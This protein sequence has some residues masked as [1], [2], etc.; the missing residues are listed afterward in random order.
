M[1]N[2]Q[3]FIFDTNVIV[4]AFLFNKSKPRQ[5]FD[6]A[7]DIGIIIL[8]NPIFSELEEVLSRPK[9]NKYLS[10][11]RRKEFLDNFM[12]TVQFIDVNEQID[13]CRDSKDN[14]FLELAVSG[15]AKC[16][17]S[18]DDDLLILNPFRGIE[19]L[20]V[21]KFLENEVA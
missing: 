16:I 1:T 20:T 3:R 13:E 21:Q 17:V 6:L 4:S 8:S 12:K 2:K 14:K 19:I 7:Q 10:V 15:K 18:G 9:F 11:E 5:A